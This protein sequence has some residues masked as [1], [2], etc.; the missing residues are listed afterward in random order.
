MLAALAGCTASGPAGGAPVPTVGDGNV[1]VDVVYLNHRPIRTV[2]TQIDEVLG[3]YQDGLAVRRLDA[4]S[5]DGRMLAEKNST[6]GHVAILLL[7]NGKPEV[8]VGGRTVRFEGFPEGTSPV[9][10]AQGTW[11]L[12]LLDRALAEQIARS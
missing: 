3:K 2:L 6:S 9:R 4:E 8:D 1:T 7:I 10:S 11:T 12:E 5:D